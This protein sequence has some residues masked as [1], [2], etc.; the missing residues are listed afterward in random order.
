MSG[1]WFGESPPFAYR[2]LEDRCMERGAMSLAVSSSDL[3]PPL[4]I[5]R[6]ALAP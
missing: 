5:G 1:A 3:A 4:G 6:E 2:A